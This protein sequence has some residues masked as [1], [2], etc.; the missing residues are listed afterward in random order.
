MNLSPALLIG[1]V[2]LVLAVIPATGIALVWRQVNWRSSRL[3]RV[4]RNK[5]YAIA[6][7]LWLSMVAS[8]LLILGLGR[9]LWFELVRWVAFGYV[10]FVMWRQW[11]IWR[12]IITDATSHAADDDARRDTLST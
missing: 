10:A 7:V 8:A 4:L 2:L 9:P 6:T 5:S 12:E 11:L 1:T 3:G